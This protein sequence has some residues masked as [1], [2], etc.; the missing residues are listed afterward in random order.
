MT[1]LFLKGV[2]EFLKLKS[3]EFDDQNVENSLHKFHYRIPIT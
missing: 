1:Y 3:G 2:Y